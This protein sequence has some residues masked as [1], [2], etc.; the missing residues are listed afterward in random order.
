MK[1]TRKIDSYGTAKL[2]KSLLA[3][4]NCFPLTAKE[5]P[6][7][8]HTSFPTTSATFSLGQLGRPE[9]CLAFSLYSSLFF[10]GGTRSTASSSSLPLTASGRFKHIAPNLF[11]MVNFHAVFGFGEI[12]PE[13]WHVCVSGIFGSLRRS[14]FSREKQKINKPIRLIYLVPVPGR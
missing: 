8:R 7:R 14:K 13:I 1:R 9:C 10:F 6:R 11:S 3:T 5:H 4:G 12:D 2:C